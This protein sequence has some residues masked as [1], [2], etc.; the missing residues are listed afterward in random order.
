MMHNYFQN[1]LS[2][3]FLHRPRYNLPDCL[4]EDQCRCN[5]M[6]LLPQWHLILSM[7]RWS[8]LDVAATYRYMV[9]GFKYVF[10]GSV[11][12]YSASRLANL[13]NCPQRRFQMNS[14]ILNIE[15]DLTKL[16]IAQ[17]VSFLD[18]L[19]SLRSILWLSEWLNF[20]DYWDNLRIHQRKLIGIVL[21]SWHINVKCKM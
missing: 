14:V 11:L 6:L 1:P 12:H 9:Q 17:I 21:I 5:S 19:A 13:L 20:S 7:P 3:K 8:L 18:A 10:D 16:L 2:Q 4:L 15:T